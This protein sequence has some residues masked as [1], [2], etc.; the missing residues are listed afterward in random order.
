[1][2]TSEMIVDRRDLLQAIRSIQ[3]AASGKNPP[4]VVVYSE[5]GHLVLR[6]GDSKS[7]IPGV[8][9]LPGRAFISGL[10]IKI[11][12]KTIPNLPEIEITRVDDRIA[13]GKNRIGCRWEETLPAENPLPLQEAW[14]E[15]LCLREKYNL[16]E[17]EEM[18][19]KERYE[20]AIQERDRHISQ[21]Y[22]NLADLGVSLQELQDLVEL[23][24]RR[25]CR[26][27][28]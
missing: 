8:G 27:K 10:L 23:A 28:S 21:A 26:E 14:L 11:L 13:F 3:N 5:A 7:R 17:I 12:P 19:Q 9:S 22:E 2:D 16:R 1:M 18:G 25:L 20:S 24:V 6:V 4:E 15:T